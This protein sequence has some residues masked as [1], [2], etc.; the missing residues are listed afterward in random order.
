MDH[1]RSAVA[2]L[3]GLMALLFLFACTTA[4]ADESGNAGTD[5]GSESPPDA[6]A[7]VPPRPDAPPFEW[8]LINEPSGGEPESPLAGEMPELR[9][10]MFLAFS[11]ANADLYQRPDRNQFYE[12]LLLH[13]NTAPTSASSAGY[14]QY[15]QNY[16]Q[17]VLSV[18]PNTGLGIYYSAITTQNPVYTSQYQYPTIDYDQT[19]FMCDDPLFENQYD[20]RPDDFGFY[21][22][23]N[24]SDRSTWEPYGPGL[25][26]RW[27][28]YEFAGRGWVCPQTTYLCR[29]II[30][31][32][33]AQVRAFVANELVLALTEKYPSA[34]VISLDNA[35]MIRSDY[36]NWPGKNQ[37]LSPYRN[38]TPDSDFFGYLDHLRSA[39]HAVGG[40]LLVNTGFGHELGPHADYIFYEHSFLRRQSTAEFRDLLADTASAMASGASIVQR[41]NSQDVLGRLDANIPDLMYFLAAAML[42][43]ED[44]RYGFDPMMWNPA[45]FAFYP[46]Y[47]LLPT[48][49]QD[50]L[51]PYAEPQPNLFVR[52]FQ[53]G[54]VMLNCGI[55]RSKFTPAE[56]Q[57]LGLAAYAAP[58]SLN[59]KSAAIVLANCAALP[60][61]TEC[62]ALYQNWPS[63][64]P[65]TPG[66]MNCDLAVNTED[67]TGFT[68]ARSSS[69]AYNLLYPYCD[70]LAADMDGDGQFT[71]YDVVLFDA[72]VF[73]GGIPPEPDLLGDMDCDGYLNNLDIHPFLMA[74]LA[75]E[76]YL[77]QYS[78][79]DI[80]RAD[81]D[82]DGAIRLL[83]T[84]PFLAALLGH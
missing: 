44:G 76:D 60:Q 33:N 56:Y 1:S 27:P 7:F 81:M 62:P 31:V 2:P 4:S 36:D 73:H 84:D 6:H 68:L 39:L 20:P 46:Q 64:S 72:A 43:Y 28:Y 29:P 80:S 53:N 42:V 38:R 17:Q 25:F 24:L 21:S 71:D 78:G 54:V 41:Y 79:C 15:W 8:G 77:V 9:R 47:F 18:N 14:T 13:Y 10:R 57:A 61:N 35:A 70:F 66:D 11:F 5:S 83:D 26:G 30:K 12:V 50:P 63:Q 32:G 59:A 34:N 48:W 45:H 58:Y 74:M 19:G 22:P 65:V 40:K 69:A 52:K 49:L 67:Q 55:H 75:P 16:R 23:P 82:Q 37:Q 3:R 51:G